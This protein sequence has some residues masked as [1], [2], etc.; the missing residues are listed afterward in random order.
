MWGARR[1]DQMDPVEEIDGWH[2]DEAAIQQIDAILTRCIAGP[3]LTEFM[4]SRSG[5]RAN[6]V[7]QPDAVWAFKADAFRA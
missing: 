3:V 2:I 6:S 7:P 5:G 4:A 1:P